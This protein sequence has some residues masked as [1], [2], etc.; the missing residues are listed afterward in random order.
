MA[1]DSVP[2]L[3]RRPWKDIA[4]ELAQETKSARIAELAE[5]LNQALAE[6]ERGQPPASKL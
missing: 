6:Q 5:E 4:R 1:A 3:P 2:P